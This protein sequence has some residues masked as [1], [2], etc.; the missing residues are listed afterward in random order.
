MPPMQGRDR[1]GRRRRAGCVPRSWATRRQATGSTRTGG[2]TSSAPATHRDDSF[3]RQ[4]LVPLKWVAPPEPDKILDGF[5]TEPGQEEQIAL[6]SDGLMLFLR[7]GDI[8]WLAAADGWVTLH[9]GRA[10]YLVSETLAAVEAKLPRGQ[11]LHLAPTTLVNVRQIRGVE[12]L[13]HGRCSVVLR[14]GTRLTFLGSCP[15]SED[16]R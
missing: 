6:N 2:Q 12:P 8:E 4:G 13:G 15:L 10:T 1:F 5:C 9:V 7:P 14:S 16:P 11:F 3:A